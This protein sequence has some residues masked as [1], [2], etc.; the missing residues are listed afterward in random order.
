[1]ELGKS[2]TWL[3]KTSGAS[4]AVISA[5]IK[6]RSRRSEFAARWAAALEVNDRWLLDG[7]G[8]KERSNVLL[9]ASAPYVTGSSAAAQRLGVLFDALPGQE[10]REAWKWL[11]RMI[12]KSPALRHAYEQFPASNERVRAAFGAP[13]AAKSRQKQR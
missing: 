1:M 13:K 7:V 8:P 10:Q 12:A 3:S 9:E 5:A 11:V 4:V 2:L 6:R